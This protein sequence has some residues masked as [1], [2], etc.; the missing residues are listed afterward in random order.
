M[1]ILNAFYSRPDLNEEV[2]IIFKIS[3]IS[4]IESSSRCKEIQI[5]AQLLWRLE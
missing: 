1:L 2:K 5:K 4:I 3:V